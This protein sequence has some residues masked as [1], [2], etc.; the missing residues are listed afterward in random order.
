MSEEN[1]RFHVIDL[2]GKSDL[3][4]ATTEDKDNTTTP[5]WLVNINNLTHSAIIG[6][7]SY[8]RL[9][10]W[11]GEESRDKMPDLSDSQLK[12]SASIKSSPITLLV[13]NSGFI[14]NLED[15]MR[16]GKPLEVVSIVRLGS[17]QNTNVS[18]QLI[19]FTNCYVNSLQQI[20]NDLKISF[21]PSA[22]KNT[23][24][25]Y[26][27]DGGSQGQLVTNFDYAKNQAT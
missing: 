22:K 1:K 20:S 5:E 21:I 4:L 11:N 23:V 14:T 13:S 27:P 26:G 16:K 3:K 18:L 9:I 17:I 10:A 6:Y 12:T 7:E 8:T 25:V 15:C 24:Y 19:D 2:P